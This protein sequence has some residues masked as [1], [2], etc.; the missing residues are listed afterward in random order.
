MMRVRGVLLFVAFLIAAAAPRLD[1]SFRDSGGR[2]F[3]SSRLVESIASNSGVRLSTAH[4]LVVHA[5][6]PADPRLKAQEEAN[7]EL[8]FED[9]QLLFVVSLASGSMPHGYHTDPENSAKVSGVLGPFG[10]ALLD[11]S[12]AILLQATSLV[13]AQEITSAIRKP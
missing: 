10:V 6:S 9:L 1:F 8:D 2:L 12:G 7:A 13:S 3:R 5:P 11:A 4:L